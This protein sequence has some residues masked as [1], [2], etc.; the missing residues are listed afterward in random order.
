M[1]GERH[2]EAKVVGQEVQVSVEDG[3]RGGDLEARVVG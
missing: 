1:G 2:L 3:I